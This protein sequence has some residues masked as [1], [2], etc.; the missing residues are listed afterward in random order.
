M[1]LRILSLL[2]FCS[3]S[4]LPL[5]AQTVLRITSPN[6]GEH[7]RSGERFHITWDGVASSEQVRLE[8]SIDGGSTWNT[9]T[10]SATGLDYEWQVPDVPSLRCLIR[11]IRMSDQ[12]E[13]SLVLKHPGQYVMSVAFSPDG[14]RLVTSGSGILVWNLSTGAATDTLVPYGVQTHGAV[15][16]GDGTKVLEAESNW[17]KVFDLATHQ[18]LLSLQESG[19]ISAV[20][21]SPDGSRIVT[22]LGSR[23]RM[24]DAQTG[25]S[26]F[27]L[28]T[29]PWTGPSISFTQAGDRLI[30][31]GAFEYNAVTG[32]S[33]DVLAFRG[34][35]GEYSPDGS[36]IV[37]AMNQHAEILDART[38]EILHLLRGHG[39]GV[40]RARFSGDG[41][42]IATMSLDSTTKIWDAAS[43][44]LLRTIYGPSGWFT[45]IALSPDGKWLA[46]SAW[47]YTARIWNLTAPE[48]PQDVSDRYWQ[49]DTSATSAVRSTSTPSSLQVMISP[50]PSGEITT[51]NYSLPQPE[52]VTIRLIDAMGAEVEGAI[53]RF[54]EVGLHSIV[55]DLHD[56]P[57]GIYFCIVQAGDRRACSRL[58]LLH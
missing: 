36:R 25:K 22:S 58:T 57:E 42:R 38:G 19:S 3:I 12:E 44:K 49:I 55:W 17:G 26:L 21:F 39:G 46:T 43:G 30:L 41:T 10:G 51:L 40:W 1:M 9:I 56:L 24:W 15:F 16:N 47:D 52:H 33:L 2:A 6:G 5:T 45:D 48:F 32:D 50:N 20:A 27:D 29:D 37:T 7:L 35:G 14:T 4:L 31:D 53:E 34:P 8:Y 28:A 13:S 54:D 23:T 18:L 11:V